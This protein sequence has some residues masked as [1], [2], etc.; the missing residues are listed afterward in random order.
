MTANIYD[1][2]QGRAHF[3]GIGGSSMSGL[4]GYL[5]QKGYAVTGSDRTKSHKTEHLE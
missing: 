1:F 2:K 5:K 4:A 3:I